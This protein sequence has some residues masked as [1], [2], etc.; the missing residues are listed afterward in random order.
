MPCDELSYNQF[1]ETINT[2][3]EGRRVPLS[4]TVGL[5]DRC[6]LR[7]VHCFVHDPAQDQALR[8]R[9]L[10]TGQWIRLF[11]RLTEAGCLWMTMTGGEILLRPDF[12]DLYRYAKEKGFLLSLLTNGTLL[13]P[14]LVDLLAEW[15]PLL[16]EISLY[17]LTKETYEAVTGVPGAYERCMRG[18]RM[19]LEARVPLRLKTIA[20]VPTRHEVRAMYRFAA[21][22]GVEFRHDGVLFQTFYGKDIGSLRLPPEEL[23]AL[24][25]ANP[26]AVADFQRL[27][28]RYRELLGNAPR[29]FQEYLYTCG[30]GFRS[31]YL[32]PYGWM[33]LCQMTRP[34]VY[35]LV[36]GTLE[37]GWEVLGEFRQKRVSKDFECLHCALAGICQRCP[38]FSFLE[39]GDPE[40]RVE[41]T[42]AIAY[43]R[44][45]QLGLGDFAAEED[46]AAIGLG[47]QGFEKI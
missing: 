19:L 15:Y 25:L 11:D 33:G 20:M 42:C 41:Y 2:R 3:L 44:A 46:F 21:E 24:D 37:E 43:L 26:K 18:I 34:A 4:V 16:V 7:C 23:V 28:D 29:D 40:T 14:E 13:T 22:L 35:D 8:S 12:A 38:A 27:H 10:N 31:F 30:G 47:E 6:N 9:E 1:G 32:D 45:Q 17:G 36:S 39:H 5:T